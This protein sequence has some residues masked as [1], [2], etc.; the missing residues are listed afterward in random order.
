[1]SVGRSIRSALSVALAILSAEQSCYLR[2][3]KLNL[4]DP[5]RFPWR[6]VLLKVKLVKCGSGLPIRIGMVKIDVESPISR[7]VTGML[8]KLTK[9][10]G[11]CFETEILQK[12]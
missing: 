5:L 4:S 6:V 10:N 2:L 3:L 8:S 9:N 7:D 12:I 11:T 1:M